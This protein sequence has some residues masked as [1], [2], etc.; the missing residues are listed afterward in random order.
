[1]SERHRLTDKEDHADSADGPWRFCYPTPNH[2]DGWVDEIAGAYRT[3]HTPPRL[4]AEDGGQLSPTS[5][6][7]VEAAVF[8]ALHTR[9]VTPTRES[10]CELVSTIQEMSK[11]LQSE[12]PQ[13]ELLKKVPALGFSITYVWAHLGIGAISEDDAA[14]VMEAC[15]GRLQQFPAPLQMS[16]GQ[17]G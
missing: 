14:Q 11:Q 9:G 17:S 15:S 13:W 2:A 10:V 6:C 4:L 8:L 7:H 12:G 16:Q 3:S 5:G 1:M